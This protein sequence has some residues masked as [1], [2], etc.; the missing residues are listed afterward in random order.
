LTKT[1]SLNG[2][3]EPIVTDSIEKIDDNNNN[4]S[5]Q[6]EKSEEN[7]K[8]LEQI[9]IENL[10]LNENNQEKQESNDKITPPNGLRGRSKQRKYFLFK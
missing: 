10:S 6:E 9:S 4:I 8:N 2:E 3:S 7:N 5:I 1:P